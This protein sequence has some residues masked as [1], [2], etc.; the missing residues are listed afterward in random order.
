[1]LSSSSA[2][3]ASRMMFL[4]HKQVQCRHLTKLA[5]RNFS[6]VSHDDHGHGHDDHGHHHVVKADPSHHF[7]EEQDKR[8][9]VLNTLRAS[10]PCTVELSNPYRHHN[11]LP[12][13]HHGHPFSSYAF[14]HTFEEEHAVHDEPYGYELGDD[15]FE[16]QGQADYPWLILFIAGISFAHFAHAHFKFDRRKTGEVMYHQRLTAL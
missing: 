15:P 5:Q 16:A 6:A 8:F 14:S 3:S 7:L 12:M 2:T 13:L 4:L 9:L 1:M 10:A 11:D